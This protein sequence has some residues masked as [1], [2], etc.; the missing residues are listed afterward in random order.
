MVTAEKIETPAETNLAGE[1]E[2]NEI[3]SRK[4]GERQG[5]AVE[6]AEAAKKVHPGVNAIKPI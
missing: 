2:S 5:K 1:A 6:A 4:E 3:I